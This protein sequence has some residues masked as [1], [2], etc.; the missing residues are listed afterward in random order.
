MCKME[1][2]LEDRQ[3]SAEGGSSQILRYLNQVR[4]FSDIT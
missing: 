1:C 4:F 3:P 2:F